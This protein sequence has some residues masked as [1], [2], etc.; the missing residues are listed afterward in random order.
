MPWVAAARRVEFTVDVRDR[1]FFDEAAGRYRVDTGRYALQAGRDSAAA[2]RTHAVV[3]VF[4][5]VRPA[6]SVVSPRPVVAGD[7]AAGVSQR[8]F[9]PVGARI[10][11]QLTVS[12]S[13]ESRYGYRTRGQSTSLPAGMRV[14][15]ASDRPDVV[16]DDLVTGAAGV[17]TV[18]VTVDYHGSTARSSF[19][20]L[21][22]ST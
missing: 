21:V 18:T 12:L 15:Y 7:D 4:G 3:E 11:P 9:F 2:T 6:V 20:V 5:S 17:A 22:K 19:V 10:D 14:R 16:S 13:D 8:A 1:A